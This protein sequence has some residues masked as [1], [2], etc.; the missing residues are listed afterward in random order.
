MDY[1]ELRD[2]LEPRD[3]YHLQ[4][5]HDIS[6]HLEKYNELLGDLLSELKIIT[7][8]LHRQ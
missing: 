1:N 5:L 7:H 8:Y 4:E 6:N 2:K 3:L